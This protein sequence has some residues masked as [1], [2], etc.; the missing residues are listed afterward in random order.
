MEQFDPFKFKSHKELPK[1]EKDNFKKVDGGFVTNEAFE[2]QEETKGQTKRSFSQWITGKEKE[3]YINVLHEE[4]LED[5]VL[6]F[7][8]KKGFENIRRADAKNFNDIFF[9]TK[10][11]QECF[12]KKYAESKSGSF[13]KSNNELICYEN[14]PKE[15]L[16]D[17]LEVNIDEHFLVLKKVELQDIQKNE[18]SV[19]NIIDFYLEQIAKV[20][21][22][23]LKEIPWREYEKLFDKLKDLDD[24][25]IIENA[26]SIISLFNES[27]N[28]IDEAEKVFSHHDFNLNNIKK[29]D[30]RLVVF[31]FEYAGRDNAMC[32]MATFYIDI[33][34]DE[35]LSK[36]FEEK[37]K[38]NKNYNEKL[39]DLMVIRRCTIILD[40]YRK[41]KYSAF[42]QKNL[43]VFKE[44]LEKYK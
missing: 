3:S 43:S 23:F 33:C 1:E 6:H 41:R 24:N 11:G 8:E 30:D 20:D 18:Q 28:L 21:A 37:I 12:I 36:I 16:I 26:N 10:D 39:F 14:L 2:K 13:S 44:K 15:L 4:A 40:K 34:D 27:R 35:N 25:D 29:L 5:S 9:A 31:D 42:F 32:D 17:V 38:N 19:S 22:S 7:F